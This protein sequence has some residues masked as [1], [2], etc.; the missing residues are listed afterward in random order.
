MRALGENPCFEYLKSTFQPIIR[1]IH[2]LPFSVVGVLAKA[3]SLTPARFGESEKPKMSGGRAARLPV[4]CIKV[5][6]NFR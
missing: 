5:I 2:H 3:L 4:L 1:I 6:L